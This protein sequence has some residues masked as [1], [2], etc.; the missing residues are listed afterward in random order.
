MA[1]SVNYQ[2]EYM[3]EV[4]KEFVEKVKS[5]LEH[6]LS[7]RKSWTDIKKHLKVHLYN[8]LNK[9]KDQDILE[10]DQKDEIVNN[11]YNKIFPIIEKKAEQEAKNRPKPTLK[12]R[13]LGRPSFLTGA[14]KYL[15]S[16]RRSGTRSRPRNGLK[17]NRSGNSFGMG[18]LA[19]A[20]NDL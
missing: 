14:R 9:T 1:E 11:A 10:K 2:E 12:S 7:Q 17:L 15:A 20:L 16:T 6:K 4:K 18:S 3:K 5:F 19:R 13:F 8:I